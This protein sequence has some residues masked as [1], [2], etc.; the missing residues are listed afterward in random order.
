[1]ISAEQNEYLCRTGPGTPMG[2]LFRRYWIPAL[3]AKE[4]PGPDCPPVRVQLLPSGWSRSVTRAA[5][6]A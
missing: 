2:S 6:W 3:M 1:M 4:L 5:R